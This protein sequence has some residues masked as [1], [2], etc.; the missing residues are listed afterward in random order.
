MTSAETQHRSH[1][2]RASLPDKDDTG[3]F[4]ALQ[5]TKVRRKQAAQLFWDN[6]DIVTTTWYIGTK[7]C[8]NIHDSLKMNPADRPQVHICSFEGIVS[9]IEV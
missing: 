8:T 9:V 3:C 5:A 4:F 6:F 7:L 2:G 1:E